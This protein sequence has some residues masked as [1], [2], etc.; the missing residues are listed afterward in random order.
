MN[1][2]IASTDETMA[3]T[4]QLVQSEQIQQ[5]ETTTTRR[6]LP[7]RTNIKAG[8]GEE[9]ADKLETWWGNFTDTIG[10]GDE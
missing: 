5:P 4:E 2:Q 7:V 6:T 10:S 9:I 8:V 1:T 3:E